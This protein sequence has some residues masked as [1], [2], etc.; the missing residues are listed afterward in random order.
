MGQSQEKLPAEEVSV[1]VVN[2][3]SLTGEF[4][5]MH[6]SVTTAEE[7]SPSKV[8]Y[9]ELLDR[10]GNSVI[11]DLAKLEEGKAKS[12]LRIPPELPSDHYLL[13]VYTRISPYTSGAKGVFQSLVTIIN[14]TK[15]PLIVSEEAA[16]DKTPNSPPI[17]ALEVK[18]Q[19]LAAVS[20]AL[21]NANNISVVIRRAFPI[22]QPGV[23]MDFADMY[24][25]DATQKQPWFRSFMDISSREGCWIVR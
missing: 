15:P 6:I 18:K 17:E 25:V 4:I 23:A 9:M 8:I 13:R 1:H 20:L 12:Y 21:P 2:P 19:D 14:P 22:E 24:P 16:A 5:W 11:A 10:N 7:P 3:V